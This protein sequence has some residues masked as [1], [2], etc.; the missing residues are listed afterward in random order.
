M[1][2]FENYIYEPYNA[3]LKSPAT[4]TRAKTATPRAINVERNKLTYPD[5]DKWDF[6]EAQPVRLLNLKCKIFYRTWYGNSII[7]KIQIQLLIIIFFSIINLFFCIESIYNTCGRLKRLEIFARLTINGDFF[8][9]KITPSDN[10]AVALGCKWC[11]EACK[12]HFNRLGPT[13]ARQ[14]IRSQGTVVQNGFSL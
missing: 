13:G 1:K 8:P 5:G 2:N 6:I 14:C 4:L 7:L 9:L 12:W 11:D 10:F 3:A